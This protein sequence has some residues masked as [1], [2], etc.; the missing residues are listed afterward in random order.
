MP[1][2]S[3]PAAAL[4]IA[5]AVP[6]FCA[7][8]KQWCAGTWTAPA[9]KP[10]AVAGRPTILARTSQVTDPDG[11]TLNDALMGP[12]PMPANLPSAS[13]R[14]MLPLPSELRVMRSGLTPPASRCFTARRVGMPKTGFS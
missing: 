6:V 5:L 11:N 7:S 9:W 3:I 1:V 4:L 12:M 10:S 2:F 13:K 14:G 8:F